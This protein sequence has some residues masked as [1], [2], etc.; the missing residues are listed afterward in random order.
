MRGDGERVVRALGVD[1]GR[2]VAFGRSLGSLYAV[3]LAARLPQLAGVVVESGVAD[4][5]ENWPLRDELAAIDRSEADWVAAV[6]AD[7]D[8]RRKLSGY[9]GGLLVLHA[10]G[11]QFL[12]RSHAERLHAWGAGAD[13]RLVVFPSGNHNTILFANY[14][15]YVREVGAFLRRVGVAADTGAGLAAQGTS[16]GN[17]VPQEVNLNSFNRLGK[18]T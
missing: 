6:M 9:H 11:D 17:D 8:L 1:P 13:K 7:F 16:F 15:E 4:V 12:D 14:R 18:T 2:C 10:A 5:A 3:E